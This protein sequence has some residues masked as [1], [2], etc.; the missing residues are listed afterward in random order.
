VSRAGRHARK[1]DGTGLRS[2][3]TNETEKRLG[4]APQNRSRPREA[5]AKADLPP[6]HLQVRLVALGGAVKRE[7]RQLR[8]RRT[9][10]PHAV[11]LGQPV[12]ND[13]DDRVTHRRRVSLVVGEHKEA[14]RRAE[15]EHARLGRQHAVAALQQPR[16]QL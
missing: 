6:P 16:A 9:V 12:H 7:Q 3:R 15:R 2:T 4:E 11:R 5:P 13:A 14:V 1:N 8:R 10:Q